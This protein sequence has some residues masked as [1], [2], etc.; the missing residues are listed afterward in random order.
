M[1]ELRPIGLFAFSCLIACLTQALPTWLI[2]FS[3]VGIGWKFWR[4]LKMPAIL[5]YSLMILFWCLLIFDS[6]KL[7]HRDT[8]TGALVLGSLFSVLSPPHKLRIMRFH[9]GLFSL[10][11]SILIVPKETFPLWVYFG[12]CVL[13]CM[14]LV[15]HHV[16]NQ[17]MFSLI[18]LGRTLVKLALPLSLLLVPVYYFFP[19]IRNPVQQQGMS[20]ISGDLEPGQMASLAL[21]DRLAFRVRFLKE[22][23]AKSLLYWRAEVL[24]QSRGMSWTQGN[25]TKSEIVPISEP[26]EP[27]VYELMLDPQL[28]MMLPLLEHTTSLSQPRDEAGLFIQVDK[29][30]VKSNNRFLLAGATPA[31]RFGALT[32]PKLD[33]PD[34]ELSPRVQKLVAQLKTKAPKEQIQFLMN[35]YK[36][37]QYTLHPGRLTS[38]DPLDEFLFE[39]KKGFCEHFAASFATLLRLGGTPSRI[40]IGYQ[41]ASQL[42][43]STYYQVTDANAHAWTEVWIDGNWIRVDPSSVVITPESRPKETES[44]TSL[45]TAWISF[46]IQHLIEL[47]QEWSDDIGTFWISVGICAAG[48][49]LIQVWRLRRKKDEAPEWERKTQRFL[50]LL[51]QKAKVR[52]RGT[53]ETIYNYLKRVGEA[54]GIEDFLELAKL[55]NLSKFAEEE[56]AVPKL[57]T[58][59]GRCR[60]RF[61]DLKKQDKSRH[62]IAA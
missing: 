28:G 26:K 15:L 4:G 60:G 47:M 14:S 52:E 10:L 50:T 38:S 2:L 17:S 8:L 56:A 42:G 57:L 43:S 34:I 18:N 31:S 12:I 25:L 59:L 21:S 3:I 9:V 53:S 22:V 36:T 20:G 49:F 33:I 11:I 13:I 62:N 39:T 51:E 48:L 58:C 24:E 23:P 54:Y 61:P 32:P 46:S 30:V 37:F 1:G 44:L 16:P 35:M 40:V 27:I 6:P 5:L 19:E 45:I 29:K 41:G 7:I 55:Y